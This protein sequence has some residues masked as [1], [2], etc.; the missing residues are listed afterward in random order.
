MSLTLANILTRVKQIVPTTT[1]DTELQAHIL[2]RMNYLASI[3]VF[4]FQEKHQEDT[5]T[6]ASYR[7]ATPANFATMKTLIIFTADSQ[8]SLEYLDSKVFDSRFPNPSENTAEKPTY[9]TIK[10]AEGEIWFNC[11]TDIAYDLHSLFYAIPADATDLTVSQLTELAKLTLV[12]WAA[13]DGFADMKEYDR[14]EKQE[15]IGNNHLA[16]LKRRYQ[17]SIENDARFMSPKEAFRMYKG[18]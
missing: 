5:V 13:S 8:R 17:L 12:H 7:W 10:V 18:Y 4:P 14:S 2:E 16:V 9:Y 3:D 1:M 6:A 11:P 15:R